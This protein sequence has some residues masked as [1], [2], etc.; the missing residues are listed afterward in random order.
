MQKKRPLSLIAFILG[1]VGA[2]IAAIIALV[3]VLI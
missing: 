1:T 3:E 2:A